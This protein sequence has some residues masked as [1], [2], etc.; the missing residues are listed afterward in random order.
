M[1]LYTSHSLSACI[2]Y[3]WNLSIR[4][5]HSMIEIQCL[6]SKSAMQCHHA[7]TSERIRYPA[8]Q[9]VFGVV[10]IITARECFYAVII[11]QKEK[12]HK[13]LPNF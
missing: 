7:A 2:K 1:E 12:V 4:M 9:Y 6:V 8:C 11:K 13:T 5:L 10:C 3:Y